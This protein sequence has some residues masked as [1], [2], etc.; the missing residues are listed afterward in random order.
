[1]TETDPSPQHLGT[2]RRCG[3]TYLLGTTCGDEDHRQ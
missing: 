3:H 1:M 2:C